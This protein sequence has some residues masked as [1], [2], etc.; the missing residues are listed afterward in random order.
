MMIRPFTLFCAI[1]AGISG[2]VLYTQ[3]HK[4][5]ML[6][7]QIA[8]IVY[9]TQKIKARTAVLRTEWTLLNQPDRLKDLS[10]KFMPTLRPLQ[11]NQFVQMASATK[12]LPP[13][14]IQKDQSEDSTREQ[15]TQAVAASHGQ[16][17]PSVHKGEPPILITPNNQ[18]PSLVASAVV[19]KV[20]DQPTPKPAEPKKVKKN[21]IAQVTNPVS[22]TAVTTP[23]KQPR[24]KVQVA[25]VSNDNE[26]AKEP[27]K[28]E[29]SKQNHIENVAYNIQNGNTFS[30]MK[31]VTKNNKPVHQKPV[32]VANA[33][34][35]KEDGIVKVNNKKE[36]SKLTHKVAVNPSKDRPS[37]RMARYEPKKSYSESALSN[38]SDEALP[39]PVPFT[40]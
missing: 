35:N 30:R 22:T 38:N 26:Q 14:D 3:K 28:P 19:D 13:I 34:D 15:L 2:M 33:S 18:N 1:F 17:I 12:Y 16:T 10:N 6:D 29:A 40:Q 8:K 36:T 7:H 37:I 24:K 20:T 4:T 31:D 32:V 9:D 27:K 5:T 23:V 39:A 11:P 21:V 25:Q